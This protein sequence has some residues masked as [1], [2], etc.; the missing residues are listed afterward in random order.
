M[1]TKTINFEFRVDST[2]TDP[3]SVTLADPAD[4]FGVKRND[5]DAVV[6]ADDTAM[7]K[8]STGIY[9]HSFTEPA[10]G[11]TYTAYIKVVYDGATYSFERQLTGSPSPS[12]GIT[13]KEAEDTL[14]DSVVHGGGFATSKLRRAIRASG[15]RFLVQT[16]LARQVLDV[17]VSANSN[18]VNI[19]SANADFLPGRMFDAPFIANGMKLLKV[20]PFGNIRSEVERSATTSTPELIA[21]FTTS[22]AYVYPTAAEATTISLPWSAPLTSFDLDEASPENITLNIPTQYVDDWLWWGARAYLLMGA[23]GHP[24]AGPAMQEFA[25]VIERVKGD[26][27]NEGM[28]YGDRN[29]SLNETHGY[30]GFV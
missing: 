29:P 26:A 14:L 23:Q 3:T 24:D 30:G 5:T 2:L 1:A 8:Q 9:Q 27:F 25:N 18:T 6:V 28:W 10:L 20:V 17:T 21:F 16:G 13:L 12:G 11:L 7:T 19:S 4:T 15:N 22:Q